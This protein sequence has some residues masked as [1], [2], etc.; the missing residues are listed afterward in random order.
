MRNLGTTVLKTL[1]LT[2]A[3]AGIAIVQPQAGES[4]VVNGRLIEK[5]TGAA[6]TSGLVML[7]DTT[8]AIKA[9][10]ITNE[11]GLFRLEAPTPGAYYVLTEALGFEP[12]IDGILDLGEGGSLTVE[13]YISPRPVQLDSMIVAVE[14][15]MIFQNLERSGYNERQATGFGFF[16]TPDDLRQRNPSYFGDLFRHTPGVTLDG[17]GSFS[18]TQIHFRNASIRGGTCS[19]NVYVD[20]ALVNTDFGGLEDVVDI[21]QISAVEVYTRASNVPLE[22]GGTNAGCGVVLFWTR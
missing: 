12:I 5:G 17:G 2:V 21:H 1:T 6:V 16:I 10:A 4:Q 20:G 8:S 7:L 22:W 11:T 13:L 19:P 9:S 3:L 18:G 15:A 14:R